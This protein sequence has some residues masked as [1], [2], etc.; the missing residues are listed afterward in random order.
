MRDRHRQT[1]PNPGNRAIVIRILMCRPIKNKLGPISLMWSNV[2]TLSFVAVASLV[3][4]FA[5]PYPSVHGFEDQDL[6]D[7][8]ITNAHGVPSVQ[9]FVA[10]SMY[11][12]IIGGETLIFA[13]PDSLSGEKVES[14]F[15]PK[16]PAMSRMAER[17]FMWKTRRADRGIHMLHFEGTSN[18]MVDE[19]S[20]ARVEVWTANVRVR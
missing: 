2:R 16:P 18:I 5:L 14:W 3:T 20:V 4:A 12:E 10:D 6:L 15:L 9:P 8:G 11:F 17:S 7:N 19:Y 1:T 13:L